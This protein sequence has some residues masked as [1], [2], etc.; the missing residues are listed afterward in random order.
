MDYA[1]HEKKNFQ[2]APPSPDGLPAIQSRAD[3]AGY[4]L[5]L[6]VIASLQGLGES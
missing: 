1:T 6:L 5:R 4:R 3:F 2:A